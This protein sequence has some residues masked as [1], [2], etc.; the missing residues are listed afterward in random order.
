[1]TF[2]IGCTRTREGYALA[3]PP[4]VTGRRTWLS[5]TAAPT[6]TTSVPAGPRAL[7]VFLDG[8]WPAT[9]GRDGAGAR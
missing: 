3:T 9:T 6:S 7:D 8:G 4:S 2:P 1:M 5:R